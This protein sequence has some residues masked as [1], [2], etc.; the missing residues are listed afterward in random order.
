M[1]SDAPPR[2][3]RSPISFCLN[4]EGVRAK[5]RE[6]CEKA[7]GQAALAE[8]HGISAQYVCDVL[9]GRRKPGAAILRALGLRRVVLYEETGDA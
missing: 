5:L 9:K 4:V 7:G 6:E 3:K 1:P 2:R 8:Q